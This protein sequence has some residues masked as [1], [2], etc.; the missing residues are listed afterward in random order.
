MKF[1]ILR[2][3]SI[4]KENQSIIQKYD[5]RGA[6]NGFSQARQLSGGNQQKFIVGREMN[7]P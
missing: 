7:T 5:V 2:E 4:V 3:K 6:R 1:A